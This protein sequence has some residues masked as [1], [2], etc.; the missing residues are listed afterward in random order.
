MTSYGANIGQWQ[1]LQ[2]A[3]IGWLPGG[4]TWCYF[5]VLYRFGNSMENSYA[6]CAPGGTLIFN[7]PTYNIQGFAWRTD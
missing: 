3:S 1:H 6:G 7:T 4:G 2:A 5:F